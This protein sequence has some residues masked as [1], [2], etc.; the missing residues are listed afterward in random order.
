MYSSINIDLKDAPKTLPDER[1]TPEVRQQMLNF[2]GGKVRQL[3]SAFLGTSDVSEI[4][5]QQASAAVWGLLS[6][7]QEFITNSVDAGATTLTIDFSE[8]EGKQFFTIK[9]DGKGFNSAFFKGRSEIAYLETVGEDRARACSTK[10]DANW[11]GM[12]LGLYSLAKTLQVFDGDLIIKKLS[13]ASPEEKQGS[14]MTFSSTDTTITQKQFEEARVL[15]LPSQSV[16]SIDNGL[17]ITVSQ[18]V[19][20]LKDR[21]GM[22]EGEARRAVEEQDAAKRV[23]QISGLAGLDLGLGLPPPSF[24][25]FSLELPPLLFHD[26]LGTER[27]PLSSTSFGHFSVGSPFLDSQRSAA[28]VDATIEDGLKIK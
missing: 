16:T 7:L 17:S 2:V 15:A 22:S 5:L 11:G 9:D 20:M 19:E 24:P 28:L 14:E 6:S 27:S 3:Q 4:A 26:H 21:L 23:S 1:I 13:D 10:T 8:K 25:A 12:G 18:R